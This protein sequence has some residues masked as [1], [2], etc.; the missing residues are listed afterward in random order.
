MVDLSETEEIICPSCKKPLMV[1][2]LSPGSLQ[3]G[4]VC[5]PPRE[6]VI[7]VGAILTNFGGVWVLRRPKRQ[8]A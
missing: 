4:C 3:F 6:H 8:T 1:T 5:T 2:E 7:P